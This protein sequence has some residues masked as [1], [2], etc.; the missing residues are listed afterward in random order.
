MLLFTGNGKENYMIDKE[1]QKAIIFFGET[2]S[3]KS[4]LIN[5]MVNHIFDVDWADDFRLMGIDLME[6]ERNTNMVQ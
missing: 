1:P 2:G 5:T 3:G 4:T 6:E